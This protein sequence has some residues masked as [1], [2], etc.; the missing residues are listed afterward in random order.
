M[1]IYLFIFITYVLDS[2]LYCLLF[3]WL[4]H[5]PTALRDRSRVAVTSSIRRTACRS[6]NGATRWSTAPMVPTKRIVVSILHPYLLF[7]FSLFEKCGFYCCCT[8][9][10]NLGS[11]WK[12]KEPQKSAL[13][14]VDSPFSGAAATT[15]LVLWPFANNSA[16]HSKMNK[17]NPPPF[18]PLSLITLQ[19]ETRKFLRAWLPLYLRPDIIIPKVESQFFFP[20]HSC[21]LLFF[22]L[23]S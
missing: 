7:S 6:T 4:Q 20:G 9:P 17:K 1:T 8:K 10:S 21:R 3:D 18:N 15:Q 2:L 5:R 12:K 11:W 16:P 23:T 19:T 13:T 14:F 22:I